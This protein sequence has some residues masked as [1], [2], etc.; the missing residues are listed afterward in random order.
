MQTPG[1]DTA[2]TSAP[3]TDYWRSGTYY[4]TY[5]LIAVNV[6]VFII[7]VISGVGFMDPSAPDIL[8]WGGNIR[9]YT[10]AGDWWR[11]ITNVFV[12]IGF[13]HLLLNMYALL[14]IGTY[15]EPVIGR[16]KFLT[17]YL[18]AGVMAS[19]ASIW[20]ADNRVSAGASGAIFGMYGLFLALLTTNYIDKHV[21]KALLPSILVFVG[22]NLI[23][24]IKGNIDNAAH[25]GGL[26][27]GFL[28]GYAFYFL[29][30]K[31]PRPQ[32]FVIVAIVLAV[33]MALPVLSA[34]RDDTA[35][36]GM[37]WEEFAALEEKA[38]GPL[39]NSDKLD[40]AEFVRQAETISMPAWMEMKELMG[41]SKK[42][43]LPKVLDTERMLMNKYVDQRILHTQTWIQIIKE[44]NGNLWPKWD[45]ITREID[46]T[47]KQ[48]Q[49]Q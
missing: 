45:S 37:V 24:G 5:G 33:L 47:I 17:A 32:L 44:N 31:Q 48:L 43:H 46:S 8:V 34:R 27:S 41:K 16:W 39:Q 9:S 10:A 3:P 21:R 26:I 12:H 15:L 19:L 40:T 28:L 36:F 18:A 13:I 7:M 49:K 23:N 30:V 6:L 22:Y 20:W 42:Y 2:E 4:V 14:M 25:I 29:H 1:M 11:L 38:L 35:R